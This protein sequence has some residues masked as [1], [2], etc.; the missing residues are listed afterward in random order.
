MH[1]CG[2]N[3]DKGMKQRHIRVGVKKIESIHY[4][5]SYAVFDRADFTDYSSQVIPTQQCDPDQISISLFPTADDDAAIRDN[6]CVIL[7]RVMY[8]NLSFFRLSFDGII[9]WHIKHEFYEM[10]R[11]SEIVRIFLLHYNLSKCR[12]T[13]VYMDMCFI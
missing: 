6:I 11:K 13:R 9:D 12:H 10:S 4:F 1:L 8:N 5:H 2:D 3:W 7:S